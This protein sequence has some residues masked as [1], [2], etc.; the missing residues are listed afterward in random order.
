MSTHIPPRDTRTPVAP[1]P[2]PRLLERVLGGRHRP[3]HGASTTAHDL[4]VRR[5]LL[6]GLTAVLTV[7]LFVSYEG[8]HGDADPLR[9]SSAPGVL[10]VDT[11]QYA[12]AQAQQEAMAAAPSTS[13]IQKQISVA[14]R[15]LAVAAADD[16]GGPAGRQAL[17]T[18]ADLITVYHGMVQKAQLEP[19]GLLRDAYLRY[20]SSVL[21][22]R[23]SG[24]R[25]RLDQLQKDQQ[26]VVRRQTSFGWTLWLGWSVVVLLVLAL[27]AALL[28]TQVYLRRRFRRKYNRE[29]LAAVA[30]LVVGAVTL[31]LFTLWT[32][33]GMSDTRG[34][35]HG[36]LSEPS[37]ITDAGRQTAA[38][39]AYTGFRAAAAVWIVI[40]GGLL[41]ML[42]ETGLRQHI[43]DYRF[44]PR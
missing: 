35:L 2:L 33:N 26:G 36:Q 29:L 19:A 3:P 12:L 14:A 11:A 9:T 34:L 16:V 23:H 8:V 18:V 24:I 13:E 1:S 17:Q 43:N 41:M 4:T 28:E 31:T 25:T 21:E 40:G 44:R 20:A 6:L 10:A 32:H 42:A 7:C 15:S 37:A 5:R 30:L 38:N 22:D 39:L 27:A